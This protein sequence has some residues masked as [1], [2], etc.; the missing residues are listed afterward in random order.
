M[1]GFVKFMISR[2]NCLV[3]S[4][5]ERLYQAEKKSQVQEDVK[6]EAII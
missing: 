5:L 4:K 1:T 2:K 6:W 3:I